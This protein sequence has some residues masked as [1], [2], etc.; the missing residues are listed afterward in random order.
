MKV[1]DLLHERYVNI[2]FSS[3]TTHNLNLIMKG[4]GNMLHALELAKK[5]SMLKIFI[6]DYV[7]I[8]SCLQKRS[9]WRKVVHYRANHFETTF[10]TLKIVHEHKHNLQ[11]SLK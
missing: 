11:A 10:V 3:Y 1:G 2:Y 4:N 5:G 8:L 7:F 6:Y 9:G